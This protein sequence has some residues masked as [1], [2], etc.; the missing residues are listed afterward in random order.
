MTHTQLQQLIATHT[1]PEHWLHSD[2]HGIWTLKD[3]LNLTIREKR[4]SDRSD[5]RPFGEAWAKRVPDEHAVMI[6]FDLFYGAS[7]VETHYLISVDGH[8]ALLPLPQA[9]TEIVAV[10]DY[11]FARCVDFQHRLEEYIERC[12][13]KVE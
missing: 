4:S 5:E 13:L 11:S 12:G 3:D 10:Q 7:Y 9:G 2:A 8:R 1:G 6:E